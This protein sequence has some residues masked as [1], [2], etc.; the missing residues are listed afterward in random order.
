[1]VPAEAMERLNRAQ[2]VITNFHA[3]LRR[4]KVAAPKL[5]KRI[6]GGRGADEPPAFTETPDEMV[7][8]VC[9]ELQ[10]QHRGTQR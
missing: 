1:V 3:L 9:R 5:T 6:L 2:I 4:E 7:R 10:A 8:R